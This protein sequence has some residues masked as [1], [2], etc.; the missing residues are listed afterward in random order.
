MKDNKSIIRVDST[1]KSSI[2]KQALT[3]R[4]SY[5]EILW[6]IMYD[7]EDQ[8]KINQLNRINLKKRK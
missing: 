2:K 7:L 4:E 5:N 6:R 1:L 3:P 8:K